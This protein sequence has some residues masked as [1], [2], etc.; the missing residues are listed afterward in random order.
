ME[1]TIACDAG[2]VTH[3]FVGP[4]CGG[5]VTM[6]TGAGTRIELADTGRFGNFGIGWVLRFLAHATQTAR[7]AA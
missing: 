1:A 6:D 7:D 4:R 2:L 3:T 5:P